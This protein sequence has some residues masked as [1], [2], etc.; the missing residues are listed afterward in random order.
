[1]DCS[2]ACPKMGKINSCWIIALGAMARLWLCFIYQSHYIFKLLSLF[3]VFIMLL[4]KHIIECPYR[5][6]RKSSHYRNSHY[7]NV[8][9]WIWVLCKYAGVDKPKDRQFYQSLVYESLEKF[10][11]LTL[12]PSY[13]DG[14]S[15]VY[16]DGAPTSEAVK[17]LLS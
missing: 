13:W 15:C 14:I 6:Y 2:L 4:A 5:H 8:L 9:S 17:Y 1:M 10:S 12:I 7:R 3:C 11:G 16:Q